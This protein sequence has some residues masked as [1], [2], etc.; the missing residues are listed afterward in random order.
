MINFMVFNKVIFDEVSD[1]H[2]AS[3][4]NSI[5]MTELFF[6]AAFFPHQQNQAFLED[7]FF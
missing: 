1:S 5:V 7:T 6:L 4:W 2:L 3:K